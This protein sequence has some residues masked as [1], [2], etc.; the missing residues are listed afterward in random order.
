MSS[1]ESSSASSSS[2]SGSRRRQSSGGS[3][4]SDPMDTDS[5]SQQESGSRQESGSHLESGSSSQASGVEPSPITRGAWMGSNV[6]EYEID[7]LYRSRRIP[8]GV[9]CRLPGDEI[10]P[11]P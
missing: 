1:E 2:S 8:E 5:G 3:T 9:T 10:E 7:W 11:E 6:T 4:A